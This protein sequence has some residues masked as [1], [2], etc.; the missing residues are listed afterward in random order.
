MKGTVAT[1]GDEVYTSCN[2]NRLDID[3]VVK[4]VMGSDCVKEELERKPH[5]VEV[6]YSQ[7]SR[8]KKV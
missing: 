8:H 6:N 3:G 5:S 7:V 4:K 1:E 2:M